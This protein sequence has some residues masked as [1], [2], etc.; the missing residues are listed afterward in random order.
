MIYVELSGKIIGVAMEMLNELNPGLDEKRY[1]TR[2]DHRTEAAWPQSVV[3]SS[4]VE[5]SLIA[6]LLCHAI[7]ISG[8]IS[9][10]TEVIPFFISV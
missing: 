5:T 4:E 2:N 1:E 10:R 9:L 6:S 3:M 8:S 7:T